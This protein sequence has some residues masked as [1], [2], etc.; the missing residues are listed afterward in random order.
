[1]IVY[2]KNFPLKTNNST[3]PT[4]VAKNILVKFPSSV[5]GLSLGFVPKP[6]AGK[7]TRGSFVGN[8]GAIVLVPGFVV[9]GFHGFVVAGF[10]GSNVGHVL[11][12]AGGHC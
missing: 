4:E 8:H 2:L 3:K 12:V 1:L 6:S 7:F 11:V 5:C 9:A 10:P